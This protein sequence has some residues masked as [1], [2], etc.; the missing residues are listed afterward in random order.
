M[1]RTPVARAGWAVLAALGVGINVA[2]CGVPRAASG[3]AAETTPTTTSSTADYTQPA[4]AA[5]TEDPFG[6]TM[7]WPVVPG[8]RTSLTGSL[9][10][11]EQVD[12][13][14]VGPVYTGDRLYVEVRASAEFNA[15][16]AVFDADQNL[17]ITNDDRS[18]YAGLTDPRAEAIVRHDSPA[19]L[20]AVTS[21]PTAPSTGA[22][23]LEVMLT[24]GEPAL[25]QPQR[26]YLDFA[27]AS[28]VAIGTRPPVDVPE[29]DAAAIDPALAASTDQITDF[30]LT[31]VRE[32]YT[33]LDVW[34]YSSRQGTLPEEPYTTIHFGAYD[35]ALLGIAEN[36]DE[37]N[38]QLTQQAIVYVDT[39]AA[40]AVLEPSAEEVA[41]AL[42]NVASHE[43]GHLL[44]LQH[45]R[46]PRGIM[47]VTANLR[48]ML[49]NQS[50]A[51][52]P[53]NE[54]DVF[55]L[56]HQDAL[57]TLV[58]NVGGDLA[59]AKGGSLAQKSARHSWYDSGNGPPARAS[60][61]FGTCAACLKYR[62]TA[63]AARRDSRSDAPGR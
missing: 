21:S 46:D 42:A 55:P 6:K 3:A 12:V 27:G 62:A 47:D 43:T 28:D 36:V 53:L 57:G 15:A 54:D 26:V 58:E 32:D 17:L 49:G 13:F 45:T 44:G 2:G 33:G 51:R 59:T 34:F 18:Y 50:F 19:C 16:L 48:E 22:Y 9:P 41:Q 40:F 7:A 4:A 31:L 1:A 39:F 14:D 29:F 23:T 35:P 56:G 20:I 30:V 38:E 60:V 37:Y 11:A 25:P 10:T 52:S 63:E 61:T 8:A 24:E 5:A